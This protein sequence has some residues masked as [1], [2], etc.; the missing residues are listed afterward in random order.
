MKLTLV[1]RELV[2]VGIQ[3]LLVGVLLLIHLPDK[4]V[5]PGRRELL[6]RHQLGLQIVDLRRQLLPDALRFGRHYFE[7]LLQLH[8][9]VLI[10][11]LGIPESFDQ[12]DVGG[13]ASRLFY[14]VESAG[15]NP[16]EA[17]EVAEVGRDQP[18]NL[19]GQCVGNFLEAT[20]LLAHV[21]QLPLHQRLQACQ[22]GRECLLLHP[23][24]LINARRLGE[25]LRH[26]PVL[27]AQVAAEAIQLLLE[28]FLILQRPHEQVLEYLCV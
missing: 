1:V 7:L 18:L 2:H 15:V 5:C 3:R 20:T 13:P 14:Q 16:A 28:H 27:L 22:H 26:L 11:R 9:C 24:R 4:L 25:F 23:S 19:P 8:D 12:V 10:G 17:C 21:R 6:L